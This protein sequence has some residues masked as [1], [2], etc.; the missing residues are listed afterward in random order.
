MFKKFVMAAPLAVLAFSSSMAFAAGE[1]RQSIDL[2]AHVPTNTFHVQP[3][4]PISGPQSFFYRVQDGG[5]DPLSFQFD[6]R[7]TNGSIHASLE[8]LVELFNGANTI[9]V[10]VEFNGVELTTTPQMV[11]DEPT[12]TPGHRTSMRL[13]PAAPGVG[14]YPAGDYVT[15]A[16]VTFDAVPPV[17][18]P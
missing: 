13:T 4:T 8:S 12:S 16:N 18:T 2:R 14:G 5:F 10:K 9:P 7:N 1:A 11:V 3:V 15:V 6:T 17:V